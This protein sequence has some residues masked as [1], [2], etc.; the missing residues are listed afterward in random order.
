[1]G[2]ISQILGIFI[3]DLGQF[4]QNRFYKSG[5]ISTSLVFLGCRC[6]KGRVGFDEQIHGSTDEGITESLDL[7]RVVDRLAEKLNLL[8]KSHPRCAALFEKILQRLDQAGGEAEG[9]KGLF[10]RVRGDFPGMTSGAFYTALH[11]CRARLREL[12]GATADE[13][14]NR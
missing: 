4:Q 5:F 6:Q 13:D 2:K 14:D 12:M 10:D 7:G 9:S 8:S 11:R 3:S 1:M